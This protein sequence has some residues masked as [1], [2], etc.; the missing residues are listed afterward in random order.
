MSHAAGFFRHAA[1]R[2]R[3]QGLAHRL[4]HDFF[5]QIEIVETENGTKRRGDAPGFVAEQVIQKRLNHYG[6]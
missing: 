3:A 2:P 6:G 5:G 4:L 1:K